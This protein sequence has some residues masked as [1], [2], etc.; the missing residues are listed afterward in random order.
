MKIED[1]IRETIMKING[2]GQITLPKILSLLAESATEL[3]N[4][5]NELEKRTHLEHNQNM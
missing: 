1:R 5:R 2:G 3:T 4:I